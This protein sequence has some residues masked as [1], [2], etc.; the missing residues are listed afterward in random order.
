[1]RP[2]GW[3]DGPYVAI[4]MADVPVNQQVHNGPVMV[5]HRAGFTIGPAPAGPALI[6]PGGGGGGGPPGN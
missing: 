6:V 3:P 1:V 2:G 4:A 5:D